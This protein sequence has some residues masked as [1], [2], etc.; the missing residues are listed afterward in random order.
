MSRYSVTF[1]FLAPP[2]LTAMSTMASSVRILEA[3]RLMRSTRSSLVASR[4]V[5]PVGRGSTRCVRKR[6]PVAGRRSIASRR[7]LY[8][9][10]NLIEYVPSV[11]RGDGTVRCGDGTVRCRLTVAERAPVGSDVAIV[12]VHGAREAVVP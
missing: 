9:R 12:L 4:R 6:H 2:T 11:Y 5:A 8:G 10:R 3:S 7:T 1:P